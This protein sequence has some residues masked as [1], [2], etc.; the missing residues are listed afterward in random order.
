MLLALP[1]MSPELLSPDLTLHGRVLAKVREVCVELGSGTTNA[2][3]KSLGIVI[4]AGI[5][6][7]SEHVGLLPLSLCA[8]CLR[9]RIIG[10]GIRRKCTT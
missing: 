3:S 5:L 8:K 6:D 2:M 1:Q 10:F 7:G 9:E 4:H